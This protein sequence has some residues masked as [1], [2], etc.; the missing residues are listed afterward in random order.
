MGLLKLGI[1]GLG[2]FGGKI[3]KLGAEA[4]MP[5][6]I[7]NASKDDIK[8]LGDLSGVTSFVVGDG[9]GTGKSRDTSKEFLIDHIS[10]VEEDAVKEICNNCDVIVVAGSVGGGFGSGSM[11][12]LT[13]IL[14]QMYPGKLF[15]PLTTLPFDSETYTAQKHAEDAIK[16][17]KKLG[18]PYIIYDNNKYKEIPSA[19]A[20]KAVNKDII[21]GLKVIR[22]DFITESIDSDD[23]AS[24]MDARDLLTT[25]SAPGRLVADMVLINSS[26]VAGGKSLVTLLNEKIQTASHAELTSDKIIAASAVMY[27][28]SDELKGHSTAVFSE[29]YDTYGHAVSDFRNEVV[30]DETGSDFIAVILSGLTDPVERIDKIIAKRI[31]EERRILNAQA[32]VS[33]FANT[34]QTQGIKLGVKSFGSEASN[35]E[36]PDV[37]N[38]LKNLKINK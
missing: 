26:S 10:V 28:L 15:I 30:N 14:S 1:F 18:T 13:D 38:I 7:I 4:D 22:G 16:E 31:K 8:K 20:L 37:K 2:M 6:V 9:N 27:S 29:L 36:A 25:I 21:T 17:I 35:V 34:E 3:A 19:D 33:K 11:P 12:A 23:T 24:D 32:S 5:G